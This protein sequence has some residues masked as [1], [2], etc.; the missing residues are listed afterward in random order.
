MGEVKFAAQLDECKVEYEY[1]PESFTWTP[2]K[3]K[4][5]PDFRIKKRKKGSSVYMFIEYKG[6]FQGPDRTK[7]IKIK[8]EHPD[9]DIRLVFE[10]ATNKLNRASHTTYGD[11][12]DKHGFPW[13]EKEFPAEWRK[14]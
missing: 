8:E 1:E 12:A 3:R 13:A 2:A 14:E 10:R 9:L 6:N 4:Y 7:L 11:W 5:T